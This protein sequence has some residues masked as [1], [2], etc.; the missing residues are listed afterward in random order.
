MSASYITQDES[1]IRVFMED[2]E[3]AEYFLSEIER[4]GDE[5]EIL[6]VTNWYN[7]AKSRLLAKAAV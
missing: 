4:D 1:M 5:Y 2:P 6:S 3:F 7:E